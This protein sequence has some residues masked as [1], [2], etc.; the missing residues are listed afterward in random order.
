MDV[1][2]YFFT[3]VI[4]GICFFMLLYIALRALTSNVKKAKTHKVQSQYRKDQR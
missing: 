3:W 2:G 1:I 4:L